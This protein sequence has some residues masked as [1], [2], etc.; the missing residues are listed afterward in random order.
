[1]LASWSA[2]SQCGAFTREVEG[3]I[4]ARNAFCFLQQAVASF[5]KLEKMR[6]D[7]LSKIG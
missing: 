6:A 1:L 4:L 7:E 5:P 3:S 2:G